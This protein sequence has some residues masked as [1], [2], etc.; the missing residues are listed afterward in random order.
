MIVKG[1]FKAKQEGLQKIASEQPNIPAVKRHIKNPGKQMQ[2]STAH[3]LYAET[4]VP[5]HDIIEIPRT[6]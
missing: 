4:G 1:L 3:Y 5:I 6:T 2:F